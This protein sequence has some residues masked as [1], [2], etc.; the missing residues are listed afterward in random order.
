M[1]MMA[2]PPRSF[3]ESNNRLIA[4]FRL[5]ASCLVMPAS[6]PP[7]I[8]LNPAP[9]CENAFRDRTVRPNTSPQTRWICQPGISLVVTTSMLSSPN[10]VE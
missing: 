5:S 2:L 7:N 8:D 3:A 9:I 4:S 10:E 6:S 1:Q